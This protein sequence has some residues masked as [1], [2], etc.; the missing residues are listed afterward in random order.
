MDRRRRVLFVAEAVSLAHVARPVVLAQMLAPTCDVSIAS[1][2]AFDLCLRGTGLAR[3]DLDS[4]APA[5]FL[6][7]LA[8]G[9]P[10][11][12]QAELARYV[13]QDVELLQ[14]QK[15]DVVVGD[16]RLSLSISARVAGIPYMALCNAHWSPWSVHRRFP[17]P[18]I[19]LTRLL[20][21]ALAT[22]IFQMAQPIAFRL[23][24]RP[25]NALRRK[26][27][28]STF[29]DVRYAYTDGDY[30]LYADTPSL[31]PV[32]VDCPSNHHFIGP[33]VW[34]PDTPLPDWWEHVPDGPLAY[35]TLGS[36]GRVDLLPILFDALA[37]QG[38][39]CMTAT[40]GR[41]NVAPSSASCFVADYLP[42]ASAAARADFVICNGGSA[43]VYQALSEGRP[44]I[45]VCS[46]M[47][48]F[49]TMSRVQD[50][51]AGICLRAGTVDRDELSG[52]VDRMVGEP[53][54]KAAA[55]G[56]RADFARFSAGIRLRDLIGAQI[57]T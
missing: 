28:L 50:A 32:S 7:R 5:L 30:T 24:A 42:G 54:F 55:G 52:A 10:L 29:P 2:G 33:I 8:E 20:G 48:Q 17:L 18:D 51:G 38:V 40:A 31:V 19:T 41:S 57:K 39:Q 27:G 12:T 46:N 15:P 49:L 37:R 3:I 4:I 6:E 9:A 56:V 43:T 44:V 53:A 22:P 23:H 14:C 35:L 11:Y 47:D 25:L 36:T 26:H 21:P 13:E 1:A 45:G 16:F 34:S